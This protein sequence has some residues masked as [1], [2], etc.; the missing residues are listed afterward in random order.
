MNWHQEKSTSLICNK[1]LIQALKELKESQEQFLDVVRFYR[2]EKIAFNLITEVKFSGYQL[3]FGRFEL[4]HGLGLHDAIDKMQLLYGMEQAMKEIRLAQ[5]HRGYLWLAH[6][7]Q[8]V[9]Q[10]SQTHPVF[11]VGVLNE[12]EI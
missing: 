7:L 12:E 8:I 3:K 2:V 4:L 9:R 11:K 5:Q 6:V 1:L 10:I